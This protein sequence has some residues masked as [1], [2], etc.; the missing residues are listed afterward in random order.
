MQKFT[1]AEFQETFCENSGI[2]KCLNRMWK[3]RNA[4]ILQ[5][6]FKYINICSREQSKLTPQQ[7]NLALDR[8]MKKLE[9]LINRKNMRQSIPEH[10]MKPLQIHNFP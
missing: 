5:L 7:S 9:G 2:Q 4:K 3:A 1:C 8:R 10:Y 6:K